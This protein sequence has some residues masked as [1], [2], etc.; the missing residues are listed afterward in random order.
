MT[1]ST[2]LSSRVLPHFYRDSVALMAIASVT[3][4][5][6]GIVRVGAVMA[7][8]SNLGIL[9]E[10]GMLPDGL[11]AAPDDLVFV[12]RGADDATV[13]DALDAA[14][15]AAEQLARDSRDTVIRLLTADLDR[16]D[17]PAEGEAP[18]AVAPQSGTRRAAAQQPRASRKRS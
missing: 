13:T 14:Q 11:S 9:A 17:T 15:A 3:E 18:P 8:P 16:P 10:S 1:D 12:V 6:D 5:R 7:T 2:V 4:K